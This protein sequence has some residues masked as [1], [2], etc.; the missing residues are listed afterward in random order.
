MARKLVRAGNPNLFGEPAIP[1][2]WEGVGLAGSAYVGD[3]LINPLMHQIVP[4]NGS[5]IG[6]AVDAIGTGLSAWGLG[7]G[8]GMVD[9]AIGRALRRGGLILMWGKV[10]SIVVPGFSISGSIPTSF[11]F[12]LGTA[13]PAAKLNGANGVSPALKSLGVGSMGV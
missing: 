11:G 12:G 4:L 7:E 6:K 10:L 9:R 13:A 1:L 2:I 8:I 3:K 5:A